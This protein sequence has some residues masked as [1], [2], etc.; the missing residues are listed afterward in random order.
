MTALQVKKFKGSQGNWDA[1]VFYSDGSK[2]VLPCVH[3]YYFKRDV[4]GF[5]YDDP[6]TPELRRTRKFANQVELMR[7][8]GRV[9]LTTDD[10]NES[11][12]R[13]EGFF[14]RTGYVAVYPIS[15]L[16]ID[17]VGMRF[18]FGNPIRPSKV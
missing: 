1:E 11:R 8:K 18:R 7:S 12:N 15:D 9:I 5:Y 3:K 17:E 6:W 14:A 16:V 13:G 4:D 2:E 10:I